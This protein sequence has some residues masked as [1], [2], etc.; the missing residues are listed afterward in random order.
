MYAKYIGGLFGKI[1][2]K[3]CNHEKKR[4]EN[5]IK[6]LQGR[7]DGFDGKEEI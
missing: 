4:S 6:R 3:K 2:G 1:Y 5:K 7:W